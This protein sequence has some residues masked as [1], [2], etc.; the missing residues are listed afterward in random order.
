M[1]FYPIVPI[2]LLYLFYP[3]PLPF[4]RFSIQYARYQSIKPCPLST[5]NMRS[6]WVSRP[7]SAS[8]PIPRC[9]ARVPMLSS[10]LMNQISTSVLFV[11]D[12]L[13][14]SQHLPREL[15]TSP[16][17]LHTHSEVMF[18]NT[19]NSTARA[20]FILISQWDTRLHRCIIRL[21]WVVRYV[22]SFMAN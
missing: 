22:R 2:Y 6:S 1:F 19:A 14:C 17:V 15:L 13:G 21:R 12:F 11:W 18:R 10:S 5:T 7:M 4:S 16:F 20:T 8:S 3:N 9:S